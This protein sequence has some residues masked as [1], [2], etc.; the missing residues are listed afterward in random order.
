MDQ[1]V[2]I[3]SRY[4]GGALPDLKLVKPLGVNQ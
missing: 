3:V 4:G 1:E 2:M